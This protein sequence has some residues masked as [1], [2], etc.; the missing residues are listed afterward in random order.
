MKNRKKNFFALLRLLLLIAGIALIVNHHLGRL[1]ERAP[2]APAPEELK[3]AFSEIVSEQR[4]KN[5]IP[6]YSGLI[7]EEH[8]AIPA[9][10]VSTTDLPP[11]V[12][13]YNDQINLLVVIDARG[14]IQRLLLLEHRETP[15]HMR[16]VIQSGLLDRFIG[17]NLVKGVPEIDAVTGATITSRAIIRDTLAAAGLAG[18]EIFNLPTP[19]PELPS[20]RDS[21]INPKLIAVLLALAA[22][23]Y[24]RFGSRPARGRREAAW[25]LSI[26][27][28]GFYAMSPLTLVQIFQ[29]LEFNPPGLN[30]PLL[31]VLL[32][33]VTLTT[34]LFGPL[35]CSYACPFGALQEL[36]SRLPVRRWKVT[37]RIMRYARKLRYL[38]LFAAAA[39]FFGLGAASFARFEP[40]YHLFSPG[41][42]MAAG[43]LIGGTLFFSLF[44]KRFWCRFFCP[45]GACL[46][47]LSSHRRLVKLVEQGVHESGI[48]R[49]DEEP[50]A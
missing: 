9:A 30:N 34:L 12:K 24:A 29:L 6:H 42:S 15:E 39:G 38:T 44:V 2:R 8:E 22:A 49:G 21:L 25:V 20:W 46:V 7:V 36:L 28:I 35:W 45:T 1:R 14:T 5:P 18:R 43:G 13:G 26:A 33:F 40:F 41:I 50:A 48:D 27:L 16:K 23:L 11:V 32:G 3:R 37:P 17:L 31:L 19:A 47:M 10:G 4:I